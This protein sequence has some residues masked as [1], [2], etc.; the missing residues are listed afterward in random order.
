MINESEDILQP[1]VLV[2]PKCTNSAAEINNEEG[3]IAYC[4]TNTKVGFV[5][6][7]GVGGAL[8]SHT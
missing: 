1:K 3:Y 8:V 2:L 4:L 6:D 7:T 5:D